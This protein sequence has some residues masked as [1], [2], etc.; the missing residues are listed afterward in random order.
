LAVAASAGY[1]GAGPS[2]MRL[3]DRPVRP[4]CATRH[5]NRAYVLSLPV[6]GCT[7]PQRKKGGCR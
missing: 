6:L 1:R 7:P 3:R 5:Y 2:G 4:A